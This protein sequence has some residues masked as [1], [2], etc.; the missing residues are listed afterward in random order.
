MVG[1]QFDKAGQTQYRNMDKGFEEIPQQVKDHHNPR[2]LRNRLAIY[3]KRQASS[4]Q[5]AYLLKN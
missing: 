2:K 1:V 3:K 4:F 5:K